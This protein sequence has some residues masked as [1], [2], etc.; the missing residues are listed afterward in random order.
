MFVKLKMTKHVNI[1]ILDEKEKLNAI[2]ELASGEI[3][4]ESLKL[5]KAINKRG[6]LKTALFFIL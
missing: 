3:T 6:G 4:D 5:A 2:A 1:S